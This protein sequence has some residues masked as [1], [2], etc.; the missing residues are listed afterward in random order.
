MRKIPTIPRRWQFWILTGVAGAT[1]VV[2]VV[3]LI[4]FLGNRTIQI[5]GN[6][7]QQFI[8]Q[9]IQLERLNREIVTALANL[10]VRDKDEQLR[11][12]L[13]AH[14]IVFTV[15]PPPAAGAAAGAARR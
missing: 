11:E 8:N 1:L 3:N 14:G 6:N 10:S 7:R 13:A 5:E 12:L 9:S 4:L 2:V 15:N